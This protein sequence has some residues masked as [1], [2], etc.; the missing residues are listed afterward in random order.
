MAHED[1]Y[2]LIEKSLELKNDEVLKELYELVDEYNGFI[3]VMDKKFDTI[4][5]KLETLIE[6]GH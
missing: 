1:I 3:K 6:N 4:V 5:I 2:Y